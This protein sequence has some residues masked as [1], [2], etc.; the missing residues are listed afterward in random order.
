MRRGGVKEK[1]EEE[2][3]W[4]VDEGQR[5]VCGGERQRA[6]RRKRVA[7]PVHTAG[8]CQDD[9]LLIVKGA[10]ILSRRCQCDRRRH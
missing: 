10:V 8:I 7:L 9:R 5:S 1:E 3:L 6:R 2:W 4:L